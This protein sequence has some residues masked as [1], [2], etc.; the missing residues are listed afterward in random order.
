MQ[1]SVDVDITSL[2]S[3]VNFED[4][5]EKSDSESMKTIDLGIQLERFW[6]LENVQAKVLS[7]DEKICEKHY[8]QNF[9]R[10]AE[11]RYSVALPLKQ[12]VMHLGKNAEIARLQFYNME[13]RLLRN[14]ELHK[15]YC[16]FMQEYID[17]KHMEMVE[18]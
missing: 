6:Q 3:T 17:L 13:R 18:V 2:C 10:V 11:G 15:M 12:N 9:H 7:I 5:K 8:Q 14:A 16:D 1:S 4:D